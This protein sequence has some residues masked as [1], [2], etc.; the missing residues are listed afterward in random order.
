[1]LKINLLYGISYT[2]LGIRLYEQPKVDQKG[3]TVCA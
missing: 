3:T 2:V 1:M